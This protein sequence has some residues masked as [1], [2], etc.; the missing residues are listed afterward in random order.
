MSKTSSVVMLIGVAM[1]QCY[2]KPFFDLLYDECRFSLFFNSRTIKYSMY[3][4]VTFKNIFQ[5]NLIC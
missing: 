1:L 3:C 5:T 4:L 2:T